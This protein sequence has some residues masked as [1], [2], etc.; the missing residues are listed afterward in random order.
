MV[1]VARIIKDFTGAANEASARY[2]ESAA[3]QAGARNLLRPDEV[4]GGYDAGRL[5]TTTLGGVLRPLTREDLAT[6]KRNAE[7]LGKAF[8]GGITAKGVIDHSTR[9][10]RER[11]NAQIRVAL[12]RQFGDGKMH[13]VTNAG[14]ESKVTR[15]H[16]LVDFLNYSAAVASPSKSTDMA[17][18]VTGGAIKFSCDCEHHKYVFS[19]IATIGKFNAGMPQLGF[20]KL[21]NPHLVG[22]GCKHVLRVMQQLSTPLVRTHVAKMIDVGRRGDAAKVTAVTKKDAALLAKQQAKQADWK[23]TTVE[24]VGE[25]RLRLAQQRRVKEIVAK[26]NS[27]LVKPTPAKMANAKR[28]FEAQARMLAAMGG[29]SQKMLADMLRKLHGK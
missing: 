19:Y 22:V 28:K 3:Q 24:S 10:D 6:F 4:A 16:V 9:I 21:K 26:A 7:M 23:R 17:K 1:N 8:K 12:P 5:L 15:H 14:P 18:S 29:I 27:A 2:N 20:P 11:S 25:K 13:F